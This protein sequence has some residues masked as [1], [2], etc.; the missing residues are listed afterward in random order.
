MDGRQAL[1]RGRPIESSA[2]RSGSGSTEIDRCTGRTDTTRPVAVEKLKPLKIVDAQPTRRLLRYGHVRLVNAAGGIAITEITWSDI[3][4]FQPR[5]TMLRPQRSRSSLSTRPLADRLR[6]R[7]EESARDPVCS[8]ERRE[9]LVRP[10][11]P[12][13]G[14]IRVRNRRPRSGG[15]LA[16][17]DLDRDEERSEVVRLH[18][19]SLRPLASEVPGGQERP[20]PPRRAPDRPVR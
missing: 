14:W 5:Q 3:D 11:G 10:A 9:D 2:W 15:A 13:S 7:L 8:A 4:I 1:G 17:D 20:R 16:G 6:R 19:A 18:S 12:S